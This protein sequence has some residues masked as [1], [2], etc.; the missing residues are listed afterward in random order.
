[1]AEMESARL[2]GQF[3]AGQTVRHPQLGVGKILKISNLGQQ[4]RADVEFAKFGRKTLILQYAR[5]EAVAG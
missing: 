1:M 2:A 5:L 3:H 4:T